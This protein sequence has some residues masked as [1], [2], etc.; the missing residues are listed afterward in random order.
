MILNIS[1]IKQDGLIIGDTRMMKDKAEKGNRCVQIQKYDLLR[2][3]R[4]NHHER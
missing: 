1:G 2:K 3:T 4:K